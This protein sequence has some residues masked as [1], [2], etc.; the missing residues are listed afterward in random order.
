[1]KI[2]LPEVDLKIVQTLDSLELKDERGRQVGQ[3]FYGKGRGRTVFLFGQYRGSY[4]THA[5]CQAF[6]DGVLAV[7]GTVDTS[8]QS[9]AFG[10]V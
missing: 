5:E 4:K 6:I 8:T 1:M 7:I 9:K 2:D 10:G 3:Y